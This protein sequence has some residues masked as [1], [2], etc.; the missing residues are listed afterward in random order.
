MDEKRVAEWATAWITKRID[1]ER[2][3]YHHLDHTRM[4]VADV[5]EFG[6]AAG[7]S[8]KELGLLRAAGW[9]HDIGYAIDPADHEEVSAQIAPG[10]IERCGGT[11]AEAENVAALIRVTKLSTH[12]GN[13]FEELLCDADLG[14]LGT[15]VFFERSRLFRR[16][17]EQGGRSFSDLDFWRM[18][19]DFLLRMNYFS[20]AARKLRGA[21]LERN[22][23]RVVEKVRRLSE[24]A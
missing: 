21:G 20:E 22:R 9:L 1:P 24:N 6:H 12:P 16:E 10:V 8:E 18:E 7:V 13:L 17:L 19:A 2:W 11:L 23:T 15:D 5:T 4:V 14:S 3:C